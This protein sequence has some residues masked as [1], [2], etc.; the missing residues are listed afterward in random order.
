MIFHGMLRKIFHNQKF[1]PKMLRRMR[2]ALPWAQLRRQVDRHVE[3]Q[4]AE[5][6]GELQVARRRWRGV[7]AATIHWRPASETAGQG[8]LW[9]GWVC[10]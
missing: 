5:A 3:A 2:R 7:G 1:L 9:I 4:A 10:D 8:S 6:A